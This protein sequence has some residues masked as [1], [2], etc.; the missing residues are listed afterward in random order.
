MGRISR[1]TFVVVLGCYLV[2]RSTAFFIPGTTIKPVG[3]ESHNST[4]KYLK[5]HILKKSDCQPIRVNN[6]PKLIIPDMAMDTSIVN[7][8][9]DCTLDNFL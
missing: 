2:I 3:I 9:I 5:N 6:K 7:T 4:R 1:Y 8:I